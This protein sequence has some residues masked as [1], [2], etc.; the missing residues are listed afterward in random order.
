MNYIVEHH[1]AEGISS[2]DYFLLAS[3]VL[4]LC[5]PVRVSVSAFP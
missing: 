2:V 3:D 1:R 4:L 5:E